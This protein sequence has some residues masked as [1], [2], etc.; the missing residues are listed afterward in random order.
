[1]KLVSFLVVLAVLTLSVSCGGKDDKRPTPVAT[2]S[3]SGAVP[4][5]GGQMA[6]DEVRLIPVGCTVSGD[7]STG[8]S[9]NGPWHFEG[10]SKATDGTIVI[11]KNQPTWV[12]APYGANADT[13]DPKQVEADMK[14]SGCT[15]Q[16]NGK[17]CSTVTV[18]TK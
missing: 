13:E 2:A 14:K 18:V 17:A 12:K 8:S 9:A 6:K 5:C 3:T 11:V 7:V 4:N 10:K 1:M 16:V 15:F